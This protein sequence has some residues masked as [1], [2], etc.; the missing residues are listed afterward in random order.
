MSLLVRKIEYN[1][2]MQRDILKG[3][4][5]SSDAITN[6]MRTTRN[7]LSV[8]CINDSTELEEAVLAIASQ[9]DHLDTADFLIIEIPL[10]QEKHL[11]LNKSRGTT[12]YYKFADNHRDIIN[13]DYSSLGTMAGIIVESIRRLYRE[14]FTRPKLINLIKQGINDGK[15]QP[16]D[17]K[18]SVRSKLLPAKP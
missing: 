17:L 8:W 13:L 2:W 10:L 14:R 15:I 16:E 4:E 11:L 3:E 6:C 12:P 7:T 5:P 18:E 9:F 1:K